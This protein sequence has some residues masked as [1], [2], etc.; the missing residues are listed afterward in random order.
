MRNQISKLTH[1]GSSNTCKWSLCSTFMLPF[2]IHIHVKHN[3]IAL[4]LRSVL[5]C[6]WQSNRAPLFCAVTVTAENV[7]VPFARIFS[8]D[9]VFFES[10]RALDI[11]TPDIFVKVSSP[12]LHD[13]TSFALIECVPFFVRQS[14][15]TNRLWNILFSQPSHSFGCE[16][17]LDWLNG[18]DRR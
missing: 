5:H 12:L 4:L 17:R 16:I 10:D 8:S 1:D 7:A 6:D 3:R 2:V 11:R 9:V 13:L 15:M 18:R 14:K